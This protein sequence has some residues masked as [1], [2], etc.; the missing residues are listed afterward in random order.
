MS[1][2]LIPLVNIPQTFD[3]A[4][5]GV[6]YTLTCKWNDAT[7]GVWLLDIADSLTDT[8]IIAGIPLVPGVD[9]LSGLEY[10]GIDGSLFVYTNGNP[11]ALPTLDN[12]GADANLYFETS[13]S[14]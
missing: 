13:V 10:V 6:T 5:A 9:L 11:N 4:L 1:T 7:D 2:I 12:L 14:S 3:I 8:M